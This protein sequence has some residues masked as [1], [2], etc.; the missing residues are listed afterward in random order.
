MK[1]P[2]VNYPLQYSKIRKEIDTAIKK[3][4][5]RG[6]LILRVDVE[7]FEKNIAKFLGVKYGVGVNSCTDA[8][9]LSLKAAGIGKGD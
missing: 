8:M 2:F 3:V 7:K 6:D 9:I 4:L 5:N 1:V